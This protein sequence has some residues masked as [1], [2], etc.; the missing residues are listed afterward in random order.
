MGIPCVLEYRTP[1]GRHD[2][3]IFSQDFTH[4]RAIVE[5]KNNKW[6]SFNK[7]SRQYQKYKALGVPIYDLCSLDGA[8]KLAA[9]IKAIH[10]HQ[11]SLPGKPVAELQA[12]PKSQRNKRRPRRTA[13]ID[14]DEDLII[15]T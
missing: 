9:E 5:C 11:H 12:L 7:A 6:G 1:A 14:I 3:C 13:Y 4:L 8:L 10:C 2:A 15:R